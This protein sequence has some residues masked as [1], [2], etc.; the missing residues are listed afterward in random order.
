[1]NKGLAI[2]IYTCS[3]MLAGVSQL[4]LKI[5]AQKRK[6]ARGLKRLFDVKVIVA[7]LMLFL[8]IFMNMIAMRYMPYKYTSALATISYIFVLLLSRFGLKEQIDK[9]QIA[10]IILICAGIVV[11]NLS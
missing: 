8:T 7:Y 9:R 10:G 4:L 5:S 11:F 6:T 3:G 2:F 1:M